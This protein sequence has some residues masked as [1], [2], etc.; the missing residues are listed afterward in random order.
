M[1][2]NDFE[3]Q[4]QQK[5]DELKFAPSAEVWTEVE[6]RIRKEKKRRRII[7]WWLIP[8]LLLGGAAIYI[9]NN[10]GEQ[11]T[12]AKQE[13]V[14]S[15]QK[16]EKDNSNQPQTNVTTTDN[17]VQTEI[18]L[19]GEITAKKKAAD[20]L[21]EK[22]QP[23]FNQNATAEINVSKAATKKKAKAKESRQTN[24]LLVVQDQQVLVT[25]AATKKKE[26]QQAVIKADIS[27]PVSEKTAINNKEVAVETKD[28]IMVAAKEEKKSVEVKNIVAEESTVSAEKKDKKKWDIGFS[29]QAGS[30]N[31]LLGNL[32]GGA[33]ENFNATPLT[34]TGN[35]GNYTGPPIYLEAPKRGFSAGIDL[36]AQKSI[37]KKIDFRVGLEYDYLST[38]IKTGNRID[39]SRSV[40]NSI[41]DGLTIANF[42]RP[43]GGAGERSYTNRYQLL[44]F[45]ATVSWKIISGKKFNV[46][47]DN[48]IAVKQ[49]ISTNALHYDRTLQGY[50][51]D[52]KPFRKT[53]WFINTG[54]TVPLITKEKFNL[55]ISPFAQFGIRTVLK[56]GNE[57]GSHLI[58]SGIALKFLFPGKK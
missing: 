29:L 49:L 36:F 17:T 58:N 11:K 4:V 19:P 16:E 18:T 40:N 35:N 38:Q 48:G 41:S 20:V 23:G 12:I 5:M 1:P 54:L 24:D 6:K 43:P 3:K 25:D 30:S 2:V 42:Y 55:S 32:F 51:Q 31:T 57:P 33:M 39:S 47:W 22:D 26:Q 52:F 45:S 37:S 56:K 9:L 44:G 27:E 28:S 53:Q 10:N 21:V 15:K 34:N 46:Q 13:Q 14:Q 50:Y 8:G 7:F